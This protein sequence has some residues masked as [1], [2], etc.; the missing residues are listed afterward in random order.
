MSEEN[1]SP[2]KLDQLIERVDFLEQTLRQQL[3]RLHAIEQRLGLAYRPVEARRPQAPQQQKPPQPAPQNIPKPPE[4]APPGN[5]IA[6]TKPV[7]SPSPV[8]PTVSTTDRSRI[9][10]ATDAYSAQANT[11]PFR[12]TQATVA[13][14]SS[15]EW[16]NLESRIGGRW[17]LWIGI[18]AISLGVAFFLRLA[19]ESGWIGPWG[20][21]SMGVV[22]G[23]VFIIGAERLRARYPVY[24]YGLTGGGIAILYLSFFASYS[25]Y[26]L[27]PHL[28]A[29]ALMAVVTAM[30][31]LLAARYNAI[32]IAVLGLIGGFLTPILLSTGKDNQIGLFSYIALLD[33]GVLAL[34]YS[35]HWRVINY[36]SFI[37]TVLIFSAWHI[38]WYEDYKLWTTIF[39]LTFFFVIF[40]LVAVLYNVINRQP[41]R[42]LDLL[43]VLVNGLIYF[44]SSYELLDDD[45]RRLLGLFA[46][47]VAGFY[48]ALGYFTFRRDREDRLLIYT[49]L[50]L[51][52][53]F[54][55]LAV[56][57]QFDQ[58]WVTMGWAI[59]GVVMT[60]IGLRV[61]DRTSSYA[62]LALF[63]IAIAHWLMIDVNEFAYRAGGSFILLFNRRALS[64]AVMI[65]SFAA[66][67]WLHRDKESRLNSEERSLFLSVYTLAANMLAVTLLSID[68]NDYFEQKKALEEG[69]GLAYRDRWNTL[70]NTRHLTLS[71]LWIMYAMVTVIVGIAR[72]SKL[73][74]LGAL[75]LLAAATLKA[76]AFDLPYYNAEWHGLIFNQT[77]A[78]FAL[79]TIA[80]AAS[81]WLY[82]RAESIEENERVIITTLLVCAAN[83]LALV[84]MS[85]EALGYF[86][87][88]ITHTTE[89]INAARLENNKQMALSAIWTIHGGAA[90]AVGI[91]RGLKP[92]RF[93]A[94]V[95]L[96]AV[97]IKLILVDIQ[98]YDARWHAL[99]FNQTFAAFTFWVAAIAVC[100]WLYSREKR[101][102]ENERSV[103]IPALTIAGNL[104]AIVALSAEAS[105]YFQSRMNT[106]SADLA[107]PVGTLIDLELAKQLSISLVWIVYGGAML[108]TGIIRRNRLLRVM[109]LMLIGIT[110]FKVF[111]YDLAA[112]E[113]IY[114][115]ISFIVL[116]AILLGVSFLYQK[117]RWLT[118]DDAAGEQAKEAR[119]DA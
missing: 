72:R 77:F 91:L 34:A 41:V 59:E 117:L 46:V 116:G 33:L 103:L 38:E 28:A 113:R 67:I 75:V 82:S 44:A 108:T 54:L 110:I 52:F 19:I 63:G 86:G 26:S 97:A 98:F 42:W 56:P 119:Q 35:K 50:G 93:G 1:S 115:I 92:L 36:L 31:V 111:L 84:T 13:Q 70:D 69:A 15:V 106:S 109:A 23:L 107:S 80:T 22:A 18:I 48:L 94:L 9:T 90:L 100:L 10:R 61:S 24:A 104:L 66:A 45:Y 58:H 37:S 99:I 68:A 62:A 73:L 16:R 96:L 74:R 25:L 2:D 29:F 4:T 47:L 17:L 11:E 14:Q 89:S 5:V 6:H 30:A 64:C 49:F 88:A 71:T 112:L 53:L 65:A 3:A 20:R 83:I 102:D 85:A 57:I 114:R 8:A 27:I 55:A 12:H 118:E 95:L 39:F 32:P 21:V 87:R 101:I 81:A 60:W 43:L 7:E 40:A 76:V 105:G 78:S 79:L 51:A